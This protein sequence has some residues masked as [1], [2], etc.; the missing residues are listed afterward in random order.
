MIPNT[1]KDIANYIVADGKGIL[2]ADESTGTIEKR[3]KSIGVD[4]TEENRRKYRE[5][6]FRAPAMSEAIGG[7]ILFDETIKQVSTDGK[8]LREIILEKGSLPGIKVD[9]GLID[10]KTVNGEKLTQGLEGL[11]DRCREYASLGA[12]FTKWR[13]VINIDEHIPTQDCIDANMNA[14]AKYAS[15]AQKNGMVPIVEPEVIMDGSHSIDR[16]YEVTQVSLTSLFS[17]LSAEGIDIEGTLLKPN[18]VIS[19]TTNENQASVNE[20]AEKTLKCL[21]ATVPN[22]LPGIVFLSGGQSDI[23]ATAHLDCMNKIGGNP[24]KLSFSYG[25]ALQQAALKAWNGEDSN[26]ENAQN[27]FNHRALMNMKAA[28]GNWD[29]K[30]EAK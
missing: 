17:H 22:E 1:L 8:P 30:L 21:L 19:G 3:F 11:D 12:K 7:V 9:Q 5:M 16:C 24:W 6:L 26:L 14:L 28:Q 27:A 4:S 25:R 15:V 23:D 13:A 18:M 10:F 20:V 29:E 2:A